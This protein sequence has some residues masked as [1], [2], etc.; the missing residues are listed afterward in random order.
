MSGDKTIN[1]QESEMSKN[2]AD[3][4][5]AALRKKADKA[6]TEGNIVL[7]KLYDN[8]LEM[9]EKGLI[10]LSWESGEPYLTLT[11]EGVKNIEEVNEAMGTEFVVSEYI[12]EDWEDDYED[13]DNNDA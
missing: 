11:D 7:A 4:T 1:S 12:I 3:W 9:Y 6:A 2:I 8:C 5:S 13:G 10:T